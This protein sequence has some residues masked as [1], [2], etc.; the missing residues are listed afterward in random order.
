LLEALDEEFF[1]AW[2]GTP[3]EFYGTS[4]RPREGTIA[5]GYYVTTI[6][7]DAGFRIERTRL[8]QQASEH[9]VKT[10]AQESEIQRFRHAPLADLIASVRKRHGDGLFIVGMDLHVGLLRLAGDKALLC[11]SAVLEPRHAVCHDA[12]T[13]PGM[14]SQYHVIGPVLSDRRVRDWLEGK[15]V[16][17]AR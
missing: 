8:A 3:W 5:C 15:K 6:L 11:H 13:S 2:E 7:R 12:L 16:P 10:F 17:S 14:V 4:E 9:I 1:P